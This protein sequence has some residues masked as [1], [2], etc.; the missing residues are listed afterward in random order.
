MEQDRRKTDFDLF[1]THRT[2]ARTSVSDSSAATRISTSRI[3]AIC[4][5]FDITYITNNP[6]LTYE[7]FDYPCPFTSSL[8]KRRKKKQKNSSSLH[9][10]YLFTSSFTFSLQNQL[11][12]RPTFDFFATHIVKPSIIPPLPIYILH[13]KKGPISNQLHT[14]RISSNPLEPPQT[15]SSSTNTRNLFIPFPLHKRR[16]HR[17]HRID[18]SPGDNDGV[19]SIHPFLLPLLSL[20]HVAS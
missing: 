17:S 2:R 19:V 9:Q 16:S 1:P 7:K 14:A 10:I 4:A 8:K 5:P 11:K 18:V 15:N 20:W 6:F 3:T 12:L 13:Q